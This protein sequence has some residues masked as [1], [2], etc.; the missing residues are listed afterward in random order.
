VMHSEEHLVLRIDNA[1]QF[2]VGTVLYGIPRHICPTVAL[3]NEVG[4][5]RDGKVVERWPVTARARCLTI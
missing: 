5:V 1:K 4:C 3:H 2:A